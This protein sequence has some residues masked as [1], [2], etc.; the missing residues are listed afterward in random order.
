MLQP[1]Y[2][3]TKTMDIGSVMD[4]LDCPSASPSSLMHLPID[5]ISQSI[6]TQNDSLSSWPLSLCI[7]HHSLVDVDDERICTE[8]SASCAPSIRR[9]ASARDTNKYQSQCYAALPLIAP[10]DTWGH[11]AA[12]L[13]SA[14]LTQV[15][16]KT[17]V[18]RRLL[19]R[20]V[21]IM[22]LTFWLA[23]VGDLCELFSQCGPLLLSFLAASVSSAI[24]WCVMGWLLSSNMLKAAL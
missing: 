18:V 1:Y 19:G 10:S 24:A 16:G 8:H 9:L 7:P 20:P 2:N 5:K 21:T 22:T 3:D 4:G 13:G 17:T 23:S 12:L 14:S 15:I 6:A 11:I